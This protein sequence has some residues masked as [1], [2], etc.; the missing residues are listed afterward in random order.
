MFSGTITGADIFLV[1][2][3]A[4]TYS[5]LPIQRLESDRL[6]F[7]AA[8]EHSAWNPFML[9]ASGSFPVNNGLPPT[10]DRRPLSSP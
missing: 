9:I 7:I 3:G 10:I 8:I 2:L 5:N 6:E 1:G 4:R